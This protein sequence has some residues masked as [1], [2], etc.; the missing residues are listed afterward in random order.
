LA[1][2]M[3]IRPGVYIEH[4]GEQDLESHEFDIYIDSATVPSDFFEGS[5][6]Q[7]TNSI[8]GEQFTIVS[9]LE[10]NSSS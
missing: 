1:G 9:V 4:V 2:A 7:Y 10:S 5:V 3:L 8:N 6:V